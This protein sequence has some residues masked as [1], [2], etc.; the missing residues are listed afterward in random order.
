MSYE[1][2]SE[3]FECELNQD[4][5]EVPLKFREEELNFA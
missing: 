5:C 3:L 1:Y 2:L 4:E